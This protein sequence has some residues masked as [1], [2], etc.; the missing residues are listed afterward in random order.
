MDTET[1]AVI[2]GHIQASRYVS[3]AG[4]VVLLY[5]HILTFD[6]EL[7]LIWHTKMTWPK[8]LFLFN[9]YMVPVAMLLRTND[10]SGIALPVLSN[11]YCR[12]SIG[13]TTILGILTIGISNL[14]VL[15]RLWMLWDRNSRL[16]YWTGTAFLTAQIAAFIVAGFVVRSTLPFVVFDPDFHSCLIEEKPRVNIGGHWGPGLAFEIM[17]FCVVW[18]NALDRPRSCDSGIPEAMYRDGFL[19]FSVLFILRLV[20]LVLAIIAP[21]SLLF[22][23]VLFIWCAANITLSR[24]I[25]NSSQLAS[26][27]AEDEDYP[28]SFQQAS[29]QTSTDTIIHLGYELK[30]GK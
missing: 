28:V 27:A 1:L 9:R 30:P 26:D 8:L 20:N 6:Q 16:M 18:W 24:L 25:L 3:G 4:L 29:R 13:T 14:L 17:V 19:Y 15:L 7:Q 2:I 10:F 5:D 12:W 21:V 11:T 23:G 22:L